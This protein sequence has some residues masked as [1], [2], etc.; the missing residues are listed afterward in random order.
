MFRLTACIT[1][2]GS[3]SYIEARSI[4]SITLTTENHNPSG[5]L[6]EGDKLVQWHG[7]DGVQFTDHCCLPC[8]KPHDGSFRLATPNPPLYCRARSKLVPRLPGR[9]PLAAPIGHAV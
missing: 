2:F 6:I 7:N 8:G 3:T 5:E 4:L 9:S 1:T